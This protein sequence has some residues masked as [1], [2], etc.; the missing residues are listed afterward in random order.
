[1]IS[2]EKLS[3]SELYEALEEITFNNIVNW[4]RE[5]LLR[6]LGGERA[7]HVIPQS[8][9]RHKL[10]RDG[11]LEIIFKRGGKTVVVSPRAIRILEEEP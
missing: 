5:E 7:I 6:I 11:I 3:K 1:M 10:N 9:Q 4:R 2:L 8:N